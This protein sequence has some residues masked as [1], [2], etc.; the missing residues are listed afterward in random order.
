M[1]KIRRY[2]ISKD[3]M[4]ES[5]E[6]LKN[7]RVKYYIY[8]YKIMKRRRWV[9]LVRWDNLDSLD[10]IDIYDENGNY[11]RSEEFPKRSIDDLIKI[12]KTFRKNIIAMNIDNL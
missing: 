3:E 8:S 7:E 6:Y 4:V 1:L 10:H 11:V 9:T 5:L 12:V 2:L